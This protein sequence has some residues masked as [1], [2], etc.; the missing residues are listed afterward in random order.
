MVRNLNGAS[1]RKV[2]EARSRKHCSEDFL[3]FLEKC[4]LADSPGPE[5]SRKGYFMLFQL[6]DTLSKRLLRRS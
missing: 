1:A 3:M 5:R 2:A 6:L 4:G